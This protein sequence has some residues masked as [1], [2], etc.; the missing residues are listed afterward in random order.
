MGYV[1]SV[2]IVKTFLKVGSSTCSKHSII[3]G[4]QIIK[5][6]DQLKRKRKCLNDELVYLKH[7]KQCFESDRKSLE[8]DADSFAERAEKERSITSIIKSDCLGNFVKKKKEEK[9]IRRNYCF[10]EGLNSDLGKSTYPFQ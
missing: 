4:T 9:R 5:E 8:K 1:F 2:N 3:A 6:E 10:G 7:T